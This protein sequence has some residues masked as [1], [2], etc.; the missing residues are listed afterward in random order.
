MATMAYT[1]TQLSAFF[2]NA[3]AGTAPSAAQTLTLTALAN[4]NASGTLTDAQALASTIDLASDTTT[5]VAVE[6]YAFFTGVAPSQAGI[7]AINSAFVGTGAQANLNGEN[8]FIAQSV[9]LALGNSAAKASF[10]AAYG[11]GTVADATKAA[12][13]V[14]I[15]NAAATAAGINV[16]SAVAFLT[17]QSSLAYYSAY[18]KAN[19]PAGTSQADLDLAVRAA[20]VGEIMFLATTYNNGAGIGSYAT[21][22]TNLIKDLSDDG[23][24]TANNAAGID[25]FANYGSNG[26]GAGTVATALTAA[27]DA[28]N[29]TSANDVYTGVLTNVAGGVTTVNLGDS[30]NGG[31]GNNTLNLISDFTTTVAGLTTSNVQTV[32]ANA[33]TA[34]TTLTVSGTGFSGVTNY[35]A[36]GAGNVTFTNFGSAT[37]GANSTVA[38]AGS[39]TV[40]A[41]GASNVSVGSTVGAG[42]AMIF[43]V[44]GG[45]QPTAVTVN[46]TA[47]TSG[48]L[49]SLV[50]DA[51]TTALNIKAGA[52]FTAGAITDAGLKTITVT[53]AATTVALGTLSTTTGLTSIDASGLTGGITANLAGNTAVTVKGGAGND[54]I[55]LAAGAVQTKAID[56]GAGTADVL[57]ISTTA[58][59]GAGTG[60]SDTSLTSTT[61]ALFT[62]FEV[63]QVSSTLTG[64]TASVAGDIGTF[65]LDNAPAGITSVRVGASQGGV[66]LNNIAAGVGVDIRGNISVVTAGSAAGGLVLNLKDASGATDTQNVTFTGATGGNGRTITNLSTNAVETIA[67]HSAGGIDAAGSANTLSLLTGSS[68]LTKVTID[69][70]TAFTIGAVANFANIVTIDGSAA[71]NGVSINGAA[72][73]TAALNLNGGASNDT[74]I[75]GTKGGSIYGGT[76]GDAVTLTTGGVHTLY[77]K[78][79]ADS[80]YDLTGV[81]GASLTQTANTGKMDAV[82]NFTTGT[83]TIDLTAFSLTSTQAIVSDKTFASTDALTAASA[84]ASF[85]QDATN[86]L[87]GVVVAHVTGNDTYMFVDTNKDGLYNSTDLV[88]K[89]VGLTHYPVSGDLVH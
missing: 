83:D 8:R 6:T 61:K 79:G 48:T 18:V 74:L 86:T 31:G 39:V 29:G 58:V 88:V 20:I 22:T 64:A 27:V 30:I 11:S 65:N 87:R 57:A 19:T 40:T 75:A 76:G 67:L 53:G 52:N 3:N 32:N 14:I 33:V 89:F 13:N 12:Y 78:T 23:A 82:T 60:P 51:A 73:G 7:A 80:S 63:L 77:Y 2:T 72:A 85:Y 84:T 38:A 69:G 55:T 16:D 10:S 46:T 37:I 66:V 62:G 25:L 41:A 5:A 9:A 24:L 4:Q 42:G 56:A 59:S 15:G 17:S 81:S 28:L 71:T 44:S 70:S 1:T 36:Q 43:D 68:A 45:A 35:N 34:A 47:G 54:T 26:T 21:A 49:T 50:L